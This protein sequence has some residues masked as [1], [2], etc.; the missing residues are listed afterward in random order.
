[1]VQKVEDL[2][3]FDVNNKASLKKT[4][5]IGTIS[6]VLRSYQICSNKFLWYNVFQ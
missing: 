2:S 4:E 5:R 1:M 6:S 3:L